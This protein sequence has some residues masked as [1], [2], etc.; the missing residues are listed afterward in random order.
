MIK[1]V[2]Y[3]ESIEQVRAL[4]EPSRQQIL[5][6]MDRGATTSKEIARAMGGSVPK[7]HYHLKELEKHGLIRTTKKEQKGNLVESHY[8]PIAST[9]KSQTHLAEEIE[10]DAATLQDV[11]TRALMVLYS[12]FEDCVIEVVNRI[13][14]ANSHEFTALMQFMLPG[15]INANHEPLALTQDEYD[16]FVSEYQALV[17]KYKKKRQSKARKPVDMFWMSFPNA[18]ALQVAKR[19][20][21]ARSRA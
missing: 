6:E 14:D 12:T 16:A 15:G 2:F 8:E 10:G 17:A 9:F 21:R 3:L 1:K 13:E 7:I 18:E 20:T 4:M 5:R 19:K 11:F